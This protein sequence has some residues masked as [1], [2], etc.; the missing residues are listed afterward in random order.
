MDKHSLRIVL[1]SLVALVALFGAW[2][3]YVI[4]T[5]P[6]AIRK[7]AYE[8]Y[9]FRMQVLVDGKAE[10]LGDKKY[11]SPTSSV[12]CTADLA[13]EPIHLHDNK[14]Q[15]VHVHWNSMTG[16]LVLKNYGWNY[17]GGLDQ[18]LGY[19]TDNA[20]DFQP[21]P[22]YGKTLPNVPKDAKLYVYTGDEKG[23]TARSFEEFRD[24]DL[25][26][27]FG[28]RSNVPGNEGAPAQQQSWLDK[29]FPKAYAHGEN[30]HG[31]A[32]HNEGGAHSHQQAG[33]DPQL[34]QLNNLL[35]NVVIFVQKDAPTDQQVKERFSKLEPLSDSV[36]GG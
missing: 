2:A 5:S 11:Q 24:T 3:A 34:T 12:A 4:N 15:M 32:G 17:I 1:A 22:I 6:A 26:Q 33:D 25:E 8:H 9:H 30:S 14:D 28:K 27:F 16:G 18:M 36:C 35:G 23:Y 13:T 29:L 20:P 7:P 31:D 19:R 21:V 10:N